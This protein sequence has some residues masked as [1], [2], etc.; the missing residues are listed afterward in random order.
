M[1]TP[2]LFY[3][4]KIEVPTNINFFLAFENY[5]DNNVVKDSNYKMHTNNLTSTTCIDKEMLTFGKKNINK[6]HCERYHFNKHQVHE[7]VIFSIECMIVSDSILTG[8][9]ASCTLP[10]KDYNRERKDI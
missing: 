3:F 8:N 7:N 4:V 9:N 10:E 1:H 6:M 5:L 2:S